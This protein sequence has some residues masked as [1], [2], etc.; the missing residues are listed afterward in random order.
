[1]TALV[2]SLLLAADPTHLT[3][4]PETGLSCQR[5]GIV[6]FLGL[7][8]TG[9]T[10]VGD[11]QRLSE[12]NHDGEPEGEF[13]RC[14]AYPEAMKALLCKAPA[15][16]CSFYPGIPD[17]EVNKRGHDGFLSGEQEEVVR[18]RAD[19]NAKSE[20]AAYML[21]RWPKIFGSPVSAN[22]I[23]GPWKDAKDLAS[24]YYRVK[25]PAGEVVIGFVRDQCAIWDIALPGGQS[26][27]DASMDCFWR[28]MN[29]KPVPVP[30]PVQ[31]GAKTATPRAP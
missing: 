3:S 23:S 14:L 8:R 25:T 21:F 27:S 20:F 12:L 19:A 7:V 11:V 6:E 22:D 24:I 4:V 17:A 30:P 31:D 5:A 10:T 1:V 26:I 29:G 28:Q 15:G 9:A 2:L 13:Q 16:P 18:K